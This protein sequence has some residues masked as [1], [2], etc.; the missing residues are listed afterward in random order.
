MNKFAAAVADSVGER[1]C[2]V[3]LGGGADSAMLL[4]A[5]LEAGPSG[6]VR[7][8][9]AF[10]GLEAS[11]LLEASARKLSESLGASKS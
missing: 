6:G 9:F 10:H 7:A 11:H 4:Q 3:A 2:V 8:V 1:P 5:T